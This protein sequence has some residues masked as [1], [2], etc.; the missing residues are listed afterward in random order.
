MRSRWYHPP[1]LHAPTD[2]GHGKAVTWLELFYDLI[3]VAA[4]IQ[5]GDFLSEDVSLGGFGLFALHF[6]PLWL[7][8]SG[9]TFYENRFNIDDVAHRLVIIVKMFA[10][11]LMAIS[12]HQAMAGEPALFALAWTIVQL[13]IVG[14]HVRTWLQVPETRAYCRYWGGVFA[15][16]AAATGIS[17]F[18]PGVWTYALWAVAILAVILSPMAAPARELSNRFPLDQHHL[19]ERYGLLTIIVLGESFV[20]VLSY[21]TAPEVEPEYLL[22]GGFNLALTCCVWWIYFD[23]VAGAKVKEQR[24]AWVV[25]FLA[26]LPLAASVTAVGVAVKKA[27]AFGFHEPAPDKYRWLLAGSLALTFLSV[28]IIDSVTERRNAKLSD[29]ARVAVRA[30]SAFI[31]LLLGQIGSGMDGGMFL[32][33]V[34][35]V[36]GAQVLFDIAMA[37]FEETTETS[38]AELVAELEKR[39]LAEGESPT[40]LNRVDISEAVVRGAPPG[41]RQDLYF[42]FLEGSW[43]RLILTWCF[44]YLVVN[45]VFAGL[46]LLEPGS[47]T[48]DAEGFADAFFFSVQTMSTIGYG[49]LAPA[50]PYGDLMV[51]IEAGVG[52]LFVAL[53][54]GLMFAKASR[55]VSAVLF[56]E[57]MVVTDFHGKRTLFIRMANARG[58]EVVEARVSVN[59]ML[60][61][62]SPEGQHMR[63]I[64]P[65]KLVR[66]STPMFVLSFVAMH[67]IDEDSPLYGRDLVDGSDGVQAFIVTLAGHDSTYGQQTHARTIYYPE[68]IREGEQFVDVISQ[69]PD[70]RLM[71][72]LTR[73]HDT[74]P[75]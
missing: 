2:H 45:V 26:H 14:L 40:R 72:D 75:V 12:S 18:I 43:V 73:F 71:L 11:G 39:R 21:L 5:L 60:S 8:W 54:T 9:F 10:V 64:R 34:A 31:I 20:K 44:L 42:F 52:M 1:V 62:V 47:I 65:L 41:L 23:D 67:V 7:V 32:A 61:E 74:E 49:A 15:V 28:A 30:A 29:G 36:C 35:A 68:D 58:N 6:V 22:K 53:G 59:A 17:I 70:G 63:R 38:S 13:I 51:T 3:F 55:P 69:L 46:Y 56:S 25:W 37:P 4:I 50:T 24:G 27:V 57:R 66:A 48:G 19:A 16:G 33:V